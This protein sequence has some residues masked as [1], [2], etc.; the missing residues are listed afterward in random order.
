MV[1]LPLMLVSPLFGFSSYF[2]GGFVYDKAYPAEYDEDGC[3]AEV[4]CGTPTKEDGYRTT[5]GEHKPEAFYG[6]AK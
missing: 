2:Y 6:G 5:C 3:W 4:T 1:F